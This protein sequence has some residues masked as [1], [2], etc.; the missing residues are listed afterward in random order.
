MPLVHANCTLHPTP[1]FFALRFVL[2]RLG[3]LCVESE[4]SCLLEDDDFS[5]GWGGF[6][7]ISY[8]SDLLVVVRMEGDEALNS[9]DIS[10]LFLVRLL[11]V[12]VQS[13]CASYLHNAVALSLSLSACVSQEKKR[14]ETERKKEKEVEGSD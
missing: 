8:R 1:P 6:L 11:S 5:S 9:Q 13:V 7:S 4:L 12:C 10:S 3:A 14:N 2:R